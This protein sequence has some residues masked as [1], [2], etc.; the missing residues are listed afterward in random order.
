MPVI[1]VFSLDEGTS[2]LDYITEKKVLENIKKMT[3]KPQLCCNSQISKSKRC[4]SNSLFEE[5]SINGEN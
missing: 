4:R 5:W 1:Q 2:A 3:N